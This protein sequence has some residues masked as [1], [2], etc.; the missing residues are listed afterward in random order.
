VRGPKSSFDTFCDLFVHSIA[1]YPPPSEG[2]HLA[3]LEVKLNHN[4]AMDWA[5]EKETSKGTPFLFFNSPDTNITK[6]LVFNGGE[7]S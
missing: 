7:E 5:S 1:D 3:F 2:Q 6:L 4:L